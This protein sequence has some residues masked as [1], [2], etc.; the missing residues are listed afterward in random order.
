[1]ELLSCY[2][3]T[4]REYVYIAAFAFH[5][6][7]VE[8]VKMGFVLALNEQLV[9]LIAMRVIEFEG[10]ISVLCIMRFYSYPHNMLFK[11]TA[12]AMPTLRLSTFVEWFVECITGTGGV[13]VLNEQGVVYI[14]YWV[15]FVCV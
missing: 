15:L 1:M 14:H 3:W 4:N 11:Y 8:Y 12:T 9:R 10:V 2:L 6:L 7:Y 13:L 5:C